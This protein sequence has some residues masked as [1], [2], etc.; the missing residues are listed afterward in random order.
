MTRTIA[1]LTCA[2]ALLLVL[3]QPRPLNAHPS[4]P[5]AASQHGLSVSGTE[6]GGTVGISEHLGTKI[7]LD[8][9]FR[10]ET[11]KP[12]RLKEL[13]TRP[14]II[15]PVYFGCTN[16]C[17]F[18]QG[19]LAAVLPTLKLKPVE[20]YKVLSISFDENETPEMAARSKRMYLTSMSTPFPEEGW[21]FL[22]GDGQTIH[23]FTESIGFSFA[24]KEHD[25][26]HPVVSLVVAPDGTIVRYLYGTTFLAKDLTLALLEARQGRVGATIRK[27]VGYCFSFDP[28]GKTYVFN[29]LR[30][31]ATVVILCVGAFLLF[32]IL[33]GRKRQRQ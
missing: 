7:P 22:T 8:L 28:V 11:G 1:W 12:V 10:D 20:E 30:V 21:R 31:A 9:T 16:V 15:L 18:L 26:V 32:L 27:V 2:S 33:T 25:F 14:T 6:S 23:T 24:R 13:I 5:P 17:N 29:L 19:G 4:E 3:I